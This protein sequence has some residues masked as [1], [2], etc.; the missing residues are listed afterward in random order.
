MT[1]GPLDLA[2][3]SAWPCPSID[4]LLRAVAL[5]DM[6]MAAAAWHDFESRS[7]FGNLTWGESRLIS[8]AAKRMAQLA[9]SSPFRPRV[10]GI[11]RSIWSRSQLAIGEVAPILRAL[12]AAKVDMLV[13]KGASRAAS[14]DPADRGRSV[15]DVDICVHPEDMERAFD[16]ATGKGWVPSGSGTILYHRSVLP[17]AV[18]IN[19]V[20]GK[21]GNLDLH[22][23]A[24][25]A[26][27]DRNE[28][29]DAIW[30]R[31]LSGKLGYADVRIPSPTDTVAI[32]IGHGAL[33]AHKRSDWLAAPVRSLDS[34]RHTDHSGE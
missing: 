24:F 19:L 11:E 3:R 27:Y 9:P 30:S 25:Q 31:S 17:D 5:N 23:T 33:E 14:G 18:G 29:D 20:H 10:A 22:R 7:D 13:I 28:D 2:L 32:A 1:N 4:N 6:P 8:L 15:N 34:E 12:Q 26:P 16:I 21:F